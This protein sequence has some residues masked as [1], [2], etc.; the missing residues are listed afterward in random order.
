[1]KNRKTNS[2]P[3]ILI[4]GS[5]SANWGDLS[6][7]IS[8][9]SCLKKAVPEAK[10]T[11]S[12]STPSITSKYVHP[13]VRVLRWPTCKSPK[14]LAHMIN[15]AILAR[16]ILWILVHKVGINLDILFLLDEGSKDVLKAYAES[17]IVLGCGGGYINNSYGS[18]SFGHLY[19]LYFAILLGKPVMLYGQ[20]LGPFRSRSFKSLARYVLERVHIIALRGKRS[21]DFAEELNL[22][23]PYIETTADAAIM[24][25]LLGRKEAE[26]ILS[27]AGVDVSKPLTTVSVK[28]WVFPGSPNPEEK[29]K[30]YIRVLSQFVD[31]IV[32]ITSG[33]V[34]FVPMDIAHNA[35]EE[36][37]LVRSLI[38][39]SANRGELFVLDGDY[40]PEARKAIIGL[41]QAHVATRMHSSIFSACAGTPILAIAY[42]HKMVSFMEALKQ[43][44]LVVDIVHLDIDEMAAKFS[45]LWES[46]SKRCET[47]GRQVALLREK[48]LRNVALVK[49]L[50]SGRK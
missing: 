33:Q 47:I 22:T 18:A 24:L 5:F 8:M 44:D 7:V 3:R 19:D 46:R 28:P 37:R 2:A 27:E 11:I 41:G 30:E 29:R 23:R 34:L 4:T 14:L 9:V 38:E 15:I 26:K 10:I 25:P 32:E 45:S 48:S 42:E 1:M 21:E 35:V 16:N 43:Q 6:I 17:D 20:S 50:L 36:S 39:R 31:R 49:G 13:G 40:S 12:A